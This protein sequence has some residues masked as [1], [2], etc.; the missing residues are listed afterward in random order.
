MELEALIDI[1]EDEDLHVLP[2][3]ALRYALQ[4]RDGSAYLRW[5]EGGLEH[6]PR[7]AYLEGDHAAHP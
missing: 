1:W 4:Q 6:S 5:L 2:R 7:R 3:R